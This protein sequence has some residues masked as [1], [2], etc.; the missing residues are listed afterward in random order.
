MA[1][2]FEKPIDAE[3]TTTSQ[4]LTFQQARDV[5]PGHEP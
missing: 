1:S 3:Q 5:E 4:Q 2:R